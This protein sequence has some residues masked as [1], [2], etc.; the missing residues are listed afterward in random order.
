MARNLHSE[1]TARIISHLKAGTIPWKQSWSSYGSGAMPRNAVSGRAYSGANVM[2]LWMTAQEKSYTDSKWLTY[3]QAT[4]LGG[5]VRK[6]EKGTTIVYVSAMEKQGDDG[7]I[8]RIPFLKAFTVFNVAQCDNLPA[9]AISDKITD[10]NPD[11]KVETAEDF[12]QSTGADI[13]NGEARAY[14]SS[15]LDYINLP[16]FESFNSASS[17]YATAFHELTHWTG[18]ETRCNRQFGKKFGD[19]S[20]SAEELVAEL[21]AAFVCA[22]FGFDNDTTEDHAAY[23]A[24]WIKFLENNERAFVHASSLASKAVEFMRGKSLEAQPS[25]LLAA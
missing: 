23:I 17:Y 16:K 5:N 7:K 24:H 18:H 13:R 11:A 4:E 22:E 1:I 20:Y 2:L 15:K 6:G 21:G 12:L 9:S 8:N 10:L 19:Q 3:K 25:E 14:Y